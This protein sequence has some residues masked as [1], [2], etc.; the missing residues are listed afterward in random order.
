MREHIATGFVVLISGDY[1]RACRKERVRVYGLSTW[2]SK[3]AMLNKRKQI[4]MQAT[5]LKRHSQARKP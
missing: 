4:G 5:E 1:L 2:I 3:T